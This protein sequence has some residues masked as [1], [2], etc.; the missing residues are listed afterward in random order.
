MIDKRGAY[1]G[2]SGFTAAEII[3][4]RDVHYKLVQEAL[5]GTYNLFSLIRRQ[6]EVATACRKLLEDMNTRRVFFDPPHDENWTQ[7]V[8]SLSEFKK[9]LKLISEKSLPGDPVRGPATEILGTI[10]RT[11]TGIKLQKGGLAVDEE[12]AR[13]YLKIMRR[14]LGR[15]IAELSR[16]SGV[17]VPS[18]L[19]LALQA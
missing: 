5:T 14:K 18:N 6:S 12:E 17:P 16:E 3:S 4:W 10:N 2:A 9:V 1:S 7:V 13:D 11:L 15:N 19:H 8:Q